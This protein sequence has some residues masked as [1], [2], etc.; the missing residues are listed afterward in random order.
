M[1]NCFSSDNRPDTKKETPSRVT[2]Q[3]GIP[4]QQSHTTLDNQ[5]GP[6]SLTGRDPKLLGGAG[7]PDLGG[8]AGGQTPISRQESQASVAKLFI[9]LYDYDARTDEDLSFKKGEQLEILNDQQGDWWYA[10][11]KISGQQGYI[12][13]NYVAKIKSLESEP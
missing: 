4:H 3:A 7:V 1:G 6:V 9:A 2:G 5:N 10:R 11:S 13:S 8:I 12:P